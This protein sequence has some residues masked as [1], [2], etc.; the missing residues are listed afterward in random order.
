MAINGSGQEL[1]AVAETIELVVEKNRQVK[2]FEI[3]QILQHATLWLA[4]RYW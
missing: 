2:R 4:S 3:Q 1:E